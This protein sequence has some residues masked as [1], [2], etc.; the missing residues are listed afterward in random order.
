MNFEVLVFIL[1]VKT[2]LFLSGEALP[3]FNDILLRSTCVW[4]CFFQLETVMKYTLKYKSSGCFQADLFR[5]FLQ[6]NGHFPLPLYWHNSTPLHYLLCYFSET[7]KLFVAML[8][9]TWPLKLCHLLT[10][11]MCW[12]LLQLDPVS[13]H[14]SALKKHPSL[15]VIL[16]WLT[17]FFT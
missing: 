10:C 6:D 13:E 4:S 11:L 9:G 2:F 5:Q 17:F 3:T 8:L 15:C 1:Q 12:I 7:V 16:C 14:I